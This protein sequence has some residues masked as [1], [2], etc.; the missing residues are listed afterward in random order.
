MT[1][2]SVARA[3]RVSRQTVSN[4]L[5]APDLVA[6]EHARRVEAVIAELGYRP[7]RAAQSLRTRAAR[8]LG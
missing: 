2:A 3:A 1:L 5:N 7:N 4:V 6:R 8:L